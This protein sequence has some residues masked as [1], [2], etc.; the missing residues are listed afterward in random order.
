ML[1]QIKLNQFWLGNIDYVDIT[2]AGRVDSEWTIQ[3][4]TPKAI[5]RRWYCVI[6][7]SEVGIF[8]S[9]YV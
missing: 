7:G 5:S 6:V 1:R 8:S 9:W 4:P 3:Q 2:N